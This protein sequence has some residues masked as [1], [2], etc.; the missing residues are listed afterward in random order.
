MLLSTGQRLVAT[1][2]IVARDPS[3]GQLGA[4]CQSH[5]FAAGAIV[6]WAEA[7]VGAVATQ[8]FVD[9]SYGPQ[10]LA[11]M[12]QG[13]SAGDALASLLEWDGDRELR[14]VAV[15][16]VRGEVASHTG[17]ETTSEAGAV[18]G[19]AHC[20]QA[21]MA[22]RASV[23]IAM[24]RAYQD[25]PG[26]L[27]ERLLVSLEAAE[28]EGGDLRGKRSAALKVVQATIGSRAGQGVLFDLRVDDHAD[29]LAELRRLT[30]LQR[31]AHHMNACARAAAAKDWATA[32][33]EY[34]A[35]ASLDGE[36]PE[37]P[38]W[39]GLALATSGDLE[40]AKPLLRKAFDAGDQ[41]RVLAGRLFKGASE[42]LD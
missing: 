19:D 24:A 4:A 39:H 2:S 3:T 5:G 9:P 21:N 40:R 32:E 7:G 15:L 33:R 41:W 20:C 17:I 31:A 11:L 28:A 8:A 27:A 10:G 30:A 22:A 1:Y 26:D 37:I 29:P 14:Q 12:R 13:L 18:S 16:D 23:W 25:A 38:F 35:A 6:T 36:N 34:A 42:L